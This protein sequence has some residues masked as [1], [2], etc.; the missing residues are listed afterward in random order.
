MKAVIVI[1]PLHDFYF[2]PHRFS[3]LGPLSLARILKDQKIDI[4]YINLPL[5]HKK[6]TRI[7][8]PSLLSYLTPYVLR[9]E[10][11]KLSFFTQYHHYG[12]GFRDS[13]ALITSK[14][15]SLVFI[16]CFAFCYGD[17]TLSLCTEIKKRN[18][19]LPV[20]VGG[21]GVSVY[22][23]YFLQDTNIDFILT[24]D[25]EVSVPLF[26]KAFCHKEIPFS[27]VPNLIRQEN[28]HISSSGIK[29][30]G[31]SEE[32]LF[33]WAATAETKKKLYIS[34]SLMRGCTKKCRFCTHWAENEVRTIPEKNIISGIEDIKKE[35]AGKEKEISLIFE[36]DNLLLKPDYFFTILSHFKK[37]LSMNSFFVEPGIDYTLLTPE[38]LKKLIHCGLKRINISLGSTNTAI[39]TA[40]KRTF[41]LSLYEKLMTI[42]KEKNI[43][44]ITYF[45][46]G[47]IGDTKEI[48]AQNLAYISQKPT[49][50]GIS[51]FYPVPGLPDFQDYSLFPTG[52]S[53]KCAG[54]SAYPWNNSLSTETLVTAFR[55]SRYGNFLKQDPSTIGEEEL[56]AIIKKNKQLHTIIKEKNKKRIIRVPNT[57]RELEYLYFNFMGKST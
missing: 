15:P 9:N 10:T 57:D 52:S 54:S 20:I 7:G 47:F 25:A 29:K 42:L 28:R 17:Q 16:S 27:D 14:H 43:P 53:N 50:C 30:K 8:I 34:T 2:T 24:G 33:T 1:P 6:G 39:L 55:L 40:E 23:E 3:G 49:L 38:L 48:V 12:P 22:P 21:P 37:Q 44:S 13:A 36:D 46:C 5:L 19:G 45:I 18:P 35:T 11:G 31:K 41:N 32:L 51:L 56:L 26:I 4:E